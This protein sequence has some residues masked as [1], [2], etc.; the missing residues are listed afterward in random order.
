MGYTTIKLGTSTADIQNIIKDGGHFIFEKGTYLITK[1][2]EISSNTFLDLNGSVLRMGAAINHILVTKTTANTTAYG[3]A[4]NIRISNGTIE[5]MGK[6]NTK[7]NLL[8]LYHAEN[9]RIENMTFLDVVEFH[10]IEV[11]SSRNVTIENCKFKGFN[12][13]IDTD[14]FREYIQIDAAVESA[15]VLHPL[16]SKC[17]DGTA[18]ENIIIKN[19][20]FTKSSSRPAASY[21]IGNHCQ[22]TGVHHKGIQILNNVFTGGDQE[23]KSGYAISLI[24]MDNVIISGNICMHYGRF[25]RIYNAT[26]SWNFHN[27]KIDAVDGDGTCNNVLIAD[28]LF[29]DPSADLSVPGIY[30]TT[31]NINH[32]GLVCIDNTGIKLDGNKNKYSHNITGVSGGYIKQAEND[33]LSIYVS[34]TSCEGIVKVLK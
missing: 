31:N 13:S 9:V 14:T 10:D 20:T 22:V 15:L 32:V 24:G 11:N 12:S 8:T 23:A 27:N 1:A 3:G 6:Y 21:C 30:V 19:C 26:Q 17:Y 4:Y 18:C 16:G 25:C 33:E 34:A 5:G 29:S 28:N 2:I 7:L